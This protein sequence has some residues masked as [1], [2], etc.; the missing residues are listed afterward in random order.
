MELATQYANLLFVYDNVIKS[1]DPFI[2][3]LAANKYSK[4][5]EDFMYLELPYTSTLPAITQRCVMRTIKNPIEWL[6]K[7]KFD[8][9]KLYN[10]L[11]AKSIRL[12]EDSIYLRSMDTISIF[13]KSYCIGKIYVWNDTYDKRQLYDLSGY[14]DKSNG[15]MEYVVAPTLQQA[16]DTI[17]NVH[18]VYDWDVDRVAEMVNAGIND[19]ILFAVADYPFNFEPDDLTKFKYELNNKRNVK[20]F[21]VYSKTEDRSYYG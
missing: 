9:D 21:S 17:G 15:K 20:P 16:I 13:L 10:E 7:K 2:L 12:Y 8:Y 1:P 4:K 3:K 6:A 19:D 14:I 18:V 5:L 11:K